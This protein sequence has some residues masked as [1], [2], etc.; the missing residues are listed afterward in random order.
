MKLTRYQKLHYLSFHGIPYALPPVGNLRFRS[1]VPSSNWSGVLDA[2]S[3]DITS[4][5]QIT[6]TLFNKFV[7][8]EDCL[9]V[10]VFTPVKSVRKESPPLPVMVWIYGGGFLIGVADSSYFGPD[11]LLEEGVIV[12]QVSYRLGSFGFLSTEDMASPGNYGLKDQHLA[13]RWVKNNIGYFGGDPERTTIFGESAGGVSVQY[14]M[15]YMKN[16]GLIQGAIS[17]S[18]SALCSWGYQRYPKKIAQDLGMAAGVNTTD[19]TVLIDYLRN[20]PTGELKGATIKVSVTNSFG[21]VNGIPFA[22]TIEPV[23]EDAFISNKSHQL[24]EEKQYLNVP[25]IIGFNT[26]EI[27]ILKPALTMALP[28]LRIFD[29]DPRIIAPSGT[30]KGNIEEVG[31]EIK[32]FYFGNNQFI[33][34]QYLEYINDA[35]FFRPIMESARL[36]NQ[37]TPTY[38]YVFTYEGSRGRNALGYRKVGD[39]KGTLHAEEMAYIWTR[40]DLPEPN[41]RDKLMSTRMVKLWTNFAKTGN[42]TPNQESITEN[43]IWPTVSDSMTYLDIGRTFSV[44][45]NFKND[46]MAFWNYIYNNYGTP[47]Y[48]TY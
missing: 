24:L 48:D 2:S 11:N 38:L 45:Q 27:S 36:F 14:Q 33:S 4:C 31:N 13:L 8:S 17:E 26:E 1:P 15:M 41:N 7:E 42:P 22:P 3:S 40:N 29:I 19:S 44:K 46:S 20:L 21:I 12:V 28:F 32:R 23:H 16:E 34:D 18:G 10:N 5:I 47:P 6:P 25:Y 43:I 30:N 39:Y 9:Y 35:Y 37:R